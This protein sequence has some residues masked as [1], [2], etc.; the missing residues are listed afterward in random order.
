MVIVSVIVSVARSLVWKEWC[1]RCSQASV[2]PMRVTTA[3]YWLA[4]Q[5]QSP[6]A[7]VCVQNKRAA[8]TWNSPALPQSPRDPCCVL[9]LN[10]CNNPCDC[11][12][13][14]AATQGLK[15]VRRKALRLLANAFFSFICIIKLFLHS[16][17]SYS[18]IIIK[19]RQDLRTS[20]EKRMP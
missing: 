10:E 19:K 6:H 7:S 2:M 17:R 11:S 20:T 9:T 18:F 16:R 8:S 12:V 15:A 1:A 4:F 3:A 5:G 14:K 13:S